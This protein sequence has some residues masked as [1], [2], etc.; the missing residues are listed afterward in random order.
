M[1]GGQYSKWPFKDPANN[2]QLQSMMTHQSKLS[3]QLASKYPIPKSSTKLSNF[4]LSPRYFIRWYRLWL[5]AMSWPQKNEYRQFLPDPQWLHKQHIGNIEQYRN[6]RHQW[7]DIHNRQTQHE[8]NQT[9]QH[10]C[11]WSHKTTKILYCWCWCSI[12]LNRRI[13][14]KI[15]WKI[16]KVA[17]RLANYMGL[18]ANMDLLASLRSR[19][20]MCRVRIWWFINRVLWILFGRPSRL[21]PPTNKTAFLVW[22]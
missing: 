14:Y 7:A 18:T 1:M 21:S 19:R 4:H 11:N 12:I 6:S 10:R 13:E 17:Q 3:I 5:I 9:N 2:R 22:V 20:G 16:H 8:D 15:I